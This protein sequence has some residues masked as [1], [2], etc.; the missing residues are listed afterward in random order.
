[1]AG[2]GSD[3]FA[4]FGSRRCK[5]LRRFLLAR[6]LGVFLEGGNGRHAL[7]SAAVTEDQKRNRAFA[8]EFL[9]PAEGIRERLTSETISADDIDDLSHAF[10]VAPMTIQHQIQ[11][12]RLATILDD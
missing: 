12:H 1:V 9:A 7:L 8:A 11:N 6:A 10:D 3:A 4:C 5:P 2:L